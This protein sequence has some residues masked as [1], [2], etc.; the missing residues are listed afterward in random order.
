[1][2]KIN[3]DGNNLARAPSTLKKERFSIFTFYAVTK[4]QVT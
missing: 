4:A 3:E 2:K 1:M